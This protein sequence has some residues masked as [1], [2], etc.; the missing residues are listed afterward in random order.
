MQINSTLSIPFVQ[1]STTDTSSTKSSA[2]AQA[3][4]AP[5]LQITSPTFSGLVQEAKDFPE[6]RSEVVAAYA[7]QVASGHYP[8]AGVISRLADLLS[9]SSS[10]S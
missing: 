5:V 3:A 8:P 6:V 7:T 1:V 10:S 9:D 2:T 4:D